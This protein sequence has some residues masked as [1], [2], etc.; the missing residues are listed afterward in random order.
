MQSYVTL[1]VQK[2]GDVVDLA[3]VVRH[4]P[5]RVG[6]DF[7]ERALAPGQ[8]DLVGQL[9]LGKRLDD[10]NDTLGVGIQERLDGIVAGGDQIGFLLEIALLRGEGDS[11]CF[12]D[13]A[14]VVFVFCVFGVL[15]VCGVCVVRGF[16]FAS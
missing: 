4:I 8:V 12:D 2:R 9:I 13:F 5:V 6:E 16:S 14:C 7:G 15:V 11:A 3:F 1:E 10:G